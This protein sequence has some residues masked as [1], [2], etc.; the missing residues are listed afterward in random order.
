M[1]VTQDCA[2]GRIGGEHVQ[3]ITDAITQ[4]APG[5]HDALTRAAYAMTDMVAGVRRGGRAN[6]GTSFSKL[7]QVLIDRWRA[8]RARLLAA[9]A[10]ATTAAY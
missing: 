7:Q 3:W 5:T 2:G 8:A 9:M 1:G 4:N 6:P 10:G